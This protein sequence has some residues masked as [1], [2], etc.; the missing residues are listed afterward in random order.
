MEARVL[1]AYASMFGSTAEIAHAIGAVLRDEYTM[2]DVLPVLDVRDL[3]H[4]DAVIVGSA[5][6]NG[7]W[8]PDAVYWLRSNEA[9]LSHMPVAYFAVCM[10]VQRPTVR[11]RQVAHTYVDAV[12]RAAPA[13][14]P[15][16]IA[17]FAGKLRYRNLPLL[18]RIVFAF[19]ARLPWGDFRDW[20]AIETWARG[21]R[22]AL[23]PA[24]APHTS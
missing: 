16:D 9:M 19:K 10:L 23:L 1:V 12:Q 24:A 2:V 6:Y 8:L 22:P 5:I 15:L 13:I 7:Q 4:Y 11:H 3:E 17:V 20:R 18:E 14:H 21:V